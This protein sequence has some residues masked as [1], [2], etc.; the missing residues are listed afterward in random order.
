MS[1]CTDKAEPRSKAYAGRGERM[2]LPDEMVGRGVHQMRP[3]ILDIQ[4]ERQRF[5]Q[6]IPVILE[7]RG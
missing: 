1:F 5:K 7:D 4:D 2:W 3:V 6:M